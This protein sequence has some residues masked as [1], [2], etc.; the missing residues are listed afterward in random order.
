MIGGGHLVRH[1]LA[2]QVGQG[3]GRGDL[4]LVI[5]GAGPHVERAAEDVGK[6]QHVV[7]LVGIVGAARGHDGIRSDLG[8]VLRA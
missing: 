1:V 6:A 3:L 4:H 8:D 5:D 2:R 7:D